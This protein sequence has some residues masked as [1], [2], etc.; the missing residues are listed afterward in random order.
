[1][2][3]AEVSA[4]GP[5]LSLHLQKSSSDRTFTLRQKSFPPLD[6][7]HRAHIESHPRPCLPSPWGEKEW[8][9]WEQHKGGEKGGSEKGG[10]KEG[11][12]SSHS[13]GGGGWGGPKS[14]QSARW[15]YLCQQETYK[16]RQQCENKECPLNTGSAPTSV[17]K[18]SKILD[19]NKSL[20]E[21]C[22][23]R[24]EKEASLKEQAKI[25][26]TS[27]EEALEKADQGDKKEELEK[28]KEELMK[29]WDL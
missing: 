6:A 5:W 22:G 10:E 7:S 13:W 17:R 26:L 29:K 15:C 4:R 2:S 21:K 11:Q 9:G 12:G 24:E 27:I 25:L 28:K 18:L 3:R 14:R 1:M 23:Q 19:E 16:G 20:K 8:D